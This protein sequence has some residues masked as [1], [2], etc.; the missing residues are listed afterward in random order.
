MRR[1]ISQVTDWLRLFRRPPAGRET[2]VH[3]TRWRADRL[4]SR[5]PPLAPTVRH[6]HEPI[7]GAAT[8]LV[9]PYITAYEREEKVR[10]QRLRRDVLW[11][12]TY[13]VDLDTR[14]IHGCPAAAS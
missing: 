6:W 11:C 4:M 1:L 14:D 9:R 3:Q 7:D 13:G 2:T 12:A 10:I 8:R 5:R